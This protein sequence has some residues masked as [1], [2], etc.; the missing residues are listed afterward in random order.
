MK[1][2]GQKLHKINV[3]ILRT[4][5]MGCILSVSFLAFVK[6]LNSDLTLF[7][8][9]ERYELLL[10]MMTSQKALTIHNVKPF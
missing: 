4:R 10:V 8:G 1:K 2:Q 6:I 3:A 7:M 5:I 9:L